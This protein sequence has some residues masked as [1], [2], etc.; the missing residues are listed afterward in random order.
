MLLT[1]SSCTFTLFWLAFLNFLCDFKMH[2]TIELERT[3]WIFNAYYFCTLFVSP[4]SLLFA[5]IPF[6]T[7][8]FFAKELQLAL[9]LIVLLCDCSI[10]VSC[11]CLMICLVFVQNKMHSII[12]N[13][14][15][16][17]MF[18]LSEVLYIVNKE[19]T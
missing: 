17:L 11:I 16:F 18:Y 5:K 2:L 19:I 3:S 4:D 12:Y 14:F 1:K 15:I 8:H 7:W 6:Y 13:M 9:N 10:D